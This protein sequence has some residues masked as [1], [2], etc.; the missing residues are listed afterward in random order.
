MPG[1][2]T[3]KEIE[4]YIKGNDIPYDK[5]GN[6]QI[7]KDLEKRHDNTV[8]T[9]SYGSEDNQDAERTLNQ[10]EYVE[11]LCILAGG[12]QGLQSQI[13][14][15]LKDSSDKDGGIKITE[16]FLDLC[17][18]FLYPDPQMTISL[19]ESESSEES[20]N[21]A[22]LEAQSDVRMSKAKNPLLELDEVGKKLMDI[23]EMCK[24]PLDGNFQLDYD[25]FLKD[26]ELAKLEYAT[27]PGKPDGD[28]SPRLIHVLKVTKKGSQRNK[29]VGKTNWTRVTSLPQLLINFPYT[30]VGE[31]SDA[32][33]TA[34]LNKYILWYLKAHVRRPES[35]MLYYQVKH[36]PEFNDLFED[37][38][39]DD[40]I[41]NR[42]NDIRKGGI[43][44]GEV[45]PS[46][47]CYDYFDSWGTFNISPLV[48]AMFLN[49]SAVKENNEFK[50]EVYT[51]PNCNH[52]SIE[53]SHFDSLLESFHTSK[54]EEVNLTKVIFNVVPYSVCLP[55]K[56]SGKEFAEIRSVFS[57]E[58]VA[59]GGPCAGPPRGAE[60]LFHLITGDNYEEVYKEK[61]T[62]FQI[63]CRTIQHLNICYNG[64]RTYSD[65]KSYFDLVYDS[66]LTKSLKKV[67]HQLKFLEEPSCVKGEN[68]SYTELFHRARLLTQSL[69]SVRLGMI[70]GTHRMTLLLSLIYNLNQ[71][72]KKYSVPMELV[73]EDSPIMFHSPNYLEKDDVYPETVSG[74]TYCFLPD[75][76]FVF[77]WHVFFCLFGMFFG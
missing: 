29:V 20:G 46:N 74:T 39:M 60:Q 50:F 4:E 71:T 33:T 12:F 3:R 59:F 30:I 51:Q 42:L 6:L 73:A 11:I 13:M 34:M 35:M 22:F 38:S 40:H 76:F 37:G 69:F 18:K 64:F 16:D 65:L 8:V 61:G 55:G 54:G 26:L 15:V 7:D 23:L 56:I 17:S 24:N 41:W 25:S 58:K 62:E 36:S 14:S 19:K 44:S 53:Q 27:V 66:I 72:D 28:L 45:I 67:K 5:Q 52:R 75:A 57:K 63:T 10:R 9:L 48:V 47:T 1:M 32:S 31:G 21:E 49:M 68:I 2:P 70:D 77:V 43:Y